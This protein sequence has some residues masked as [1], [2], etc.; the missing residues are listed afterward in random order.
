MVEAQAGRMAMD[1]LV[2]ALLTAPVYLVPG[3]GSDAGELS[4]AALEGRDGGRYIPAFTA[5]AGSSVSAA[6]TGRRACCFATSPRTG[7]RRSRS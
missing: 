1:T 4:L 5:A 2:R 3:D 6:A 7:R